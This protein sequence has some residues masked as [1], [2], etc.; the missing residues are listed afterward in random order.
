MCFWDKISRG[1]IVPIVCNN[2]RKEWSAGNDW[3]GKNL[4]RGNTRSYSTTLR[5]TI[6]KQAI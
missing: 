1:N 2:F 5:K 4:S 6:M 3:K